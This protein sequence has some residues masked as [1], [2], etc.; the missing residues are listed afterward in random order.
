MG[1]VVLHK[2]FEILS[3]IEDDELEPQLLNL[4]GKDKFDQYAG[5]IWQLKF[6][7]ECFEKNMEMNNFISP[8]DKTLKMNKED[9]KNEEDEEVREA[10]GHRRVSQPSK[11]LDTEPKMLKSNSKR[12]RQPSIKNSSSSE[13]DTLKE[14]DDYKM[15]RE[16]HKYN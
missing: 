7:Y 2:A 8:F 16:K 12:V 14:N 6:C 5:K 1:F 3:N 13:E 10:K 11:P 4:M 9:D 15:E